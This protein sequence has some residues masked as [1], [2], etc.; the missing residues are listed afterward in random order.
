VIKENLDTIRL[1][2]RN[3]SS[4]VVTRVAHALA[5]ANFFYLHGILNTI[6]AIKI[7]EHSSL[8]EA[9]GTRCGF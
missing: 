2:A 6:F 1:D 3:V 7:Q 9:G 5:D 8:T 4:A